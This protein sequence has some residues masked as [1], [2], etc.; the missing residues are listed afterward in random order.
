MIVLQLGA[1][2]RERAKKRT[3]HKFQCYMTLGAKKNDN[4]RSRREEKKKKI[5]KTKLTRRAFSLTFFP[6]S[7]YSIGRLMFNCSDRLAKPS[8]IF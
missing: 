8:T 6:T 1:C 3:K 7:S 4:M 2:D 5:I